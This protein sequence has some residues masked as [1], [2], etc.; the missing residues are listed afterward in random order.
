M[1]E[2]TDKKK[3]MVYRYL[4]PTGLKVSILGFGTYMNLG[5]AQMTYDP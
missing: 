2:S 1:V 3:N 5:N 4:G